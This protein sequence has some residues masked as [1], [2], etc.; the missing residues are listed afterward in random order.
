[1]LFYQICMVER[2]GHSL[3]CLIGATVSLLPNPKTAFQAVQSA[4][5]WG[6]DSRPL[7]GLYLLW[8]LFQSPCLASCSPGCLSNHRLLPVSASGRAEQQGWLASQ[9]TLYAASSPCLNYK[10]EFSGLNSSFNFLSY[11]VRRE[12]A[13][14]WGGGCYQ[15]FS[16][17][18]WVFQ[19]QWLLL[20]VSAVGVQEL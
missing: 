16:V 18:K 20:V 9:S 3:V 14:K 19:S 4:Q 11:S 7:V 15:H 6:H 5:V 8:K 17:F 2:G 12:S 13:Q 10:K 1:M